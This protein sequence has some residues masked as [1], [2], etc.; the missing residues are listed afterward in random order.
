VRALAPGTA[1][2]LARS[3]V[4]TTMSELSVLPGSVAALQILGLRP[5]AVRETLALRVLARDA[6]GAEVTGEPV[7]WT[8]ADSDVAT[9]DPR[10]GAVVARVP[11]TTKIT[12]IA[13]GMTE[14]GHLT[15]L[16]RPEPIHWGPEGADEPRRDPAVEAGV[17]EC[18]A[19]LR[20]NDLNRLTAMYHPSTKSDREMLKRLSRILGTSPSS[21]TVG[22]RL[23]RDP[24]IGADDA[25]MD[26]SV[27]LTWRGSS[28]EPRSSEPLFRAELARSAR[29]WELSS[30]RIVGTP[31]F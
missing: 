16:P 2:I 14:G 13:G 18:Y 25:S 4:A 20:A 12:A 19:A 1:L 29:G 23:D 27:R 7:A 9:V 17:G 26:F 28:G 15:V 5:M 31:G 8:S 22:E 11:G 10:S 24:Q 3:G 6:W 21:V 30:C